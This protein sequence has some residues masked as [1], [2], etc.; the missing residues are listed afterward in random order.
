MPQ[1]AKGDSVQVHYVGT[2]DNGDTFDSS[3]EREPIRFVI[4]AGQL[5]EPFERAVVGMAP[6]EV[7]QV[8]VAPEDG[9]GPKQDALVRTVARA[10]LPPELDLRLGMELEGPSPEGGVVR[11]RVTGLDDDQVMLDSNHP[12][13]GETLTFEIELVVIDVED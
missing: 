5:I 10:Q 3:R 13:A 6:G 4:G 12:L 8:V 1:A 2:L 11:L 9:Y 7:K